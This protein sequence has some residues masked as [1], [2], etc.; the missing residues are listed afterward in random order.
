MSTR[1]LVAISAMALRFREVGPALWVLC[2][3]IHLCLSY[4][5]NILSMALDQCLEVLP[6]FVKRMF[7]RVRARNCAL[8]KTGQT[9]IIASHD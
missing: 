7:S 1:K 9:N 4:P 5:R 2:F 8:V 6:A 3:R